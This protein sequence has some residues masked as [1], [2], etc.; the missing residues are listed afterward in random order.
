MP[1]TEQTPAR[2]E[3]EPPRDDE[4][5][6]RDEQFGPTPPH[7]VEAEQIVL[8]AMMWSADVVPDIERLL[9]AK[10]F[11]RPIHGSIFDAILAL[12]ARQAPTDP[13]AVADAL[14]GNLPRVGGAPYLHTCYA[15]VPT[16]AN[17]PY[18]AHIVRETSHLRQLQE[19]SVLIN[20]RIAARGDQGKSANIVD[21]VRE[22]LA[23]LDESS[24][25][26]GPRPW[27]EVAPEVL[28]LI[29]AAGKE[30]EPGEEVETIPTGFI[31]L[32]RLLSGG[33]RGGQL[34]V[35]AGRPG[36]G[37]SVAANGFARTAACERAITSA[38]ISLEM[39][40][41]EIGKRLLA[42][43]ANVPLHVLKNGQLTDQ[44]WSR[45]ANAIGLTG[46]APLFLDG[47][48]NVTLA[49]IR[50]RAR[51]LKRS[52]NLRLLVIDYI[53]LIETVT[54]G[55]ENRQQAVTALSRGLKLLAKEL[56]IAVI[57]VSQLNRGPEQRTDKR[58]TMSDLRESGS[59]ENDADIVILLHRDDY[60]DKESPRAGEAD[61][62]IAK[63]RDGPTDTVTV[64]APLHLSKFVDMA[65]PD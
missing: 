33:W 53:Q 42:S 10:D 64:A 19:L 31:D 59:I 45:V 57:A 61:F 38:I 11:Y 18:Y 40:E 23:A 20:H 12:A 48:P 39:G 50:S 51:K 54:R 6:A 21:E 44:D 58:P 13:Y 60:Y 29:E 4:P 63:H 65:I 28:D 7:N 17:G 35:V 56:D 43:L 9:T 14:G 25:T 41:T 49:E 24:L 34:I 32:D 26:A 27:G 5:P 52:H 62:I 47:T 16:A 22:R 3:Q 37:K 55:S 36:L 1:R 46:E 30:P 2:Y 15:R 8:G